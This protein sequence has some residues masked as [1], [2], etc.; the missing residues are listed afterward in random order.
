MLC[1]V[2]EI[3]VV[4]CY[5]PKIQPMPMSMAIILP[6]L[7]LKAMMFML[8]LRCIGGGADNCDEGDRA[9]TQYG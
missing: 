4:R 3:T 7:V 9:R 5:M 1:A 6:V 8:K 2:S